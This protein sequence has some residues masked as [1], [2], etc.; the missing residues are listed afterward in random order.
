MFA[1]ATRLFAIVAVLA[2]IAVLAV[3]APA[4]VVVR[5]VFPA[6]AQRFMID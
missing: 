6:S 4:D 2:P 1:S 3:P 5:G